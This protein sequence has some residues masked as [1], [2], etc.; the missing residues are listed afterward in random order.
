MVGALTVAIVSAA[1]AGPTPLPDRWLLKLVPPNLPALPDALFTTRWYGSESVSPFLGGLG[2]TPRDVP[3]EWAFRPGVGRRPGTMSKVLL[4]DNNRPPE[5]HP[6][7]VHRC[8]VEFDRKLYTAAVIDKSLVLGVPVELPNRVWYQAGLL[9]D[10]QTVREWRLEFDDDPRAN[11]TGGVTV[12]GHVRKLADPDGREVRFQTRFKSE[13]F[14][15]EWVVKF[16]DVRQEPSLQRFTIPAVVPNRRDLPFRVP[17]IVAGGNR[18][19]RLVLGSV[20]PA[21]FVPSPWVPSPAELV[22]PPKKP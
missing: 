14:G 17:E 7:A 8:L 22:Q 19:A 20:R 15:G 21:V 11:R 12:R 2:T 10:G 4:G 5:T 18:P 13:G 9:D 16:L 1:L 6:L 3:T